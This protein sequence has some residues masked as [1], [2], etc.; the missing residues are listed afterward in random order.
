MDLSRGLERFGLDVST[1]QLASVVGAFPGV[2]V[3]SVGSGPGILERTIDECI[4]VDPAPPEGVVVTASTVDELLAVRPELVG[5]CVLL[6]VWCL[7]NDSTYD[8]D[9]VQSLR[10]KAILTLLEQFDDSYGAAGGSKFHEFLKQP[11][12]YRQVHRTG[13]EDETGPS[14]FLWI[15]LDR[16]DQP[17]RAVWLRDEVEGRGRP[18]GDC[19]IC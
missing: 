19:T 7:P 5:E 3:V 2:P 10:P 15:H 1:K 11:T 17:H 4:T 16:N 6:L 13:I 12:G 9:A 8:W 14:K 18:A